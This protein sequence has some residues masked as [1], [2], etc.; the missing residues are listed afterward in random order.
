MEICVV[1]GRRGY[2]RN[3]QWNNWT[4]RINDEGLQ[5]GREFPAEISI[6]FPRGVEV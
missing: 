6:G 1:Q 5:V 3:V 4:L 2:P